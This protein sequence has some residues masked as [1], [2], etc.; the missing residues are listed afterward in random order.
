MSLYE[1]LIWLPHNLVAHPLK[2]FMPY[3]WGVWLHNVTIPM[4]SKLKERGIQ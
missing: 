1:R 2:V 4:N 3:D